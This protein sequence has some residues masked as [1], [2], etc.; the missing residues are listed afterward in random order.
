MINRKIKI[1]LL[2]A[3]ALLLTLFLLRG[4][5]IRLVVDS[6]IKSVNRELSLDI[7][8]KK[9]SVSGL[10]GVRIDSLTI[11]PVGKEE[12]MRA[13]KIVVRLNAF[14]LLFLFESN[15]G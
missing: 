8:Y 15:L 11:T 1:A 5:I 12:L 6:R 9:L 3:A 14:K 4:A 10:A 2:A 7:S 13:S